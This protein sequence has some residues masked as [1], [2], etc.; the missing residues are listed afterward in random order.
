[1]S[2]TTGIDI[3]LINSTE[4]TITFKNLKVGENDWESPPSF[5]ESMG[6]SKQQKIHGEAFFFR[7][8][9][10]FSVQVVCD[11]TPLQL[12][13]DPYN[14]KNIIVARDQSSLNLTL[15]CVPTGDSYNLLLAVTAT[16]YK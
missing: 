16:K 14:A 8:T 4:K 3:T 13:Q 7:K 12:E 2:R 11:D 15:V 10:P 1:M 6:P 9:V 5:P